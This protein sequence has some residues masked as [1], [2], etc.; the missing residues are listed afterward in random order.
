MKLQ[1]KDTSITIQETLGYRVLNV[2][3]VRGPC[4]SFIWDKESCLRSVI[5]RNAEWREA[6]AVKIGCEL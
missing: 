3:S 2:F 1:R 6:S 4:R 5:K